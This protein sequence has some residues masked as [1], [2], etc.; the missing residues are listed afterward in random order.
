[1]KVWTHFLVVRGPQALIAAIFLRRALTRSA[2]FSTTWLLKID[3]LQPI[4]EQPGF[5]LQDFLLAK[6]LAT[7]SPLR[8]RQE[9]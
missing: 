2:G 3:H 9:P 8:H 5:R 7:L 1:M 4:A 6:R